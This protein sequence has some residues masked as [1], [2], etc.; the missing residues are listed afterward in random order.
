M[1]M[2]SVLDGTRETKIRF[3]VIRI[4]LT[5]TRNK[6]IAARTIRVYSSEKTRELLQLRAAAKR[7]IQ[8]STCDVIN[9]SDFKGCTSSCSSAF[10]FL[11]PPAVVIPS[12]VKPVL[13]GPFIKRNFVLNRNIFRSSDYHS[14]S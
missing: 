12:A 7:E 11:L 5:T 3:Y 9:Y 13:N 2:E 8:Q 14:I 6:P 10:S 4:L 1:S